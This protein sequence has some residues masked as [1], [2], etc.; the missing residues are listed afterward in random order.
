MIWFYKQIRLELNQLE[1][2]FIFIHNNKIIPGF[3]NKYMN[4]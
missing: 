1:K 2:I 3:I 4:K